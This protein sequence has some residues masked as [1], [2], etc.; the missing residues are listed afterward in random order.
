M[1][2]TKKSK[3]LLFVVGVGAVA[4]IFIAIF[5]NLDA[6]GLNAIAASLAVLASVLAA[7][8]SLENVE[9]MRE[10]LNPNITVYFDVYSRYN[11][12]QLCMKNIGGSP[13]YNIKFEWEGKALVDF[14][15]K[16]VFFYKSGE[17]N[18]ITVLQP[19][20]VLYS[21]V[22]VPYKVFEDEG[23]TFPAKLTY[24]DGFGKSR[25]KTIL[26][27]L[28]HYRGSLTYAKE[29]VKAMYQL[30]KIDEQVNKIITAVN[31]LTYEVSK[32]GEKEAQ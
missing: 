20:E 21:K 32:L 11:F 30:S 6:A 17:P 19:N 16:Q 23:L 13:A 28:E 4:I 5:S 1:S 22:N 9:L 2:K 14:N 8:S 29:E 18:G 3:W 10:Q 25:K 15:D 26:L 27:S 7:S 24:T 12:I 31:K